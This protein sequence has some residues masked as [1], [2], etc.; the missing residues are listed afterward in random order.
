[1][2]HPSHV[3]LTCLCRASS[4]L[5]RLHALLSSPA[6]SSPTHPDFFDS[7][8]SV[9]HKY[10]Q[11]LIHLNVHSCMRRQTGDLDSLPTPSSTSSQ[12]PDPRVLAQAAELSF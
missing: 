4:S 7:L 1:M 3:V 2:L 12:P 5:T 10:K 6:L 11:L 8:Q 9:R